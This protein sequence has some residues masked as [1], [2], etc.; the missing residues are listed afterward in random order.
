MRELTFRS[1]YFRLGTL[2]KEKV[3]CKTILALTATATQSTQQSIREV[4]SIPLGNTITDSAMPP[5]IRLAVQNVSPGR[6]YPSLDFIYT[7]HHTSKL[8]GY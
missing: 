7:Q 1:A 8:V 5:N 2:I 3:P 4:L 6:S